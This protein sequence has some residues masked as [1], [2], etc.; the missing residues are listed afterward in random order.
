MSRP[1]SKS[2]IEAVSGCP[3]SDDEKQWP[4]AENP[5]FLEKPSKKKAAQTCYC[6][7][8]VYPHRLGSGGCMAPHAIA[9]DEPKPQ[10]S[11][12]SHGIRM[13]DPYATGDSPTQYEC[14][15]PYC[16]WETT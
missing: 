1:L 5:A 16:P 8:L 12:C 4:A 14:T 2:E 3:L 10:C 11:E 6:S 9:K 13:N 15:I 7:A